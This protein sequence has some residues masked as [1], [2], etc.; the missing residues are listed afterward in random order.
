MGGMANWNRKRI[1][2]WAAA[3]VLSIW[4]PIALAQNYFRYNAYILP[5]CGLALALLCTLLILTGK[6]ASEKI[7]AFHQ[8]FGIRRPL[9]Y[10]LII[11]GIGGLLLL[12]LGGGEWYAIRKSTEH[13]AEL[14]KS[15]SRI[16]E[17]FHPE[18]PKNPPVA[19]SHSS[20][21]HQSDNH[22][23]PATTK[24]SIKKNKLLSAVKT[25]PEK[26]NKEIAPSTP[27]ST[28]QPGSISQSNS[29]G[30]NVQQGTTGNNSPII[31]SP[32]T[33]GD[34]PKSISPQDMSA[35]TS[36]FLNAKTK[37]K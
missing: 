18:E 17:N 30:I 28:T 29:G 7:H 31:N 27:P 36:Y 9:E 20:S 15:D 14:K 22:P 6:K 26:G 3:I 2:G 23:G 33:V 16:T 12:V 35:L 10:F 19:D 34:V 24:G 13:V 25:E 1:A 11:A 37:P 8:G 5:V 32:I 4:L 21:P